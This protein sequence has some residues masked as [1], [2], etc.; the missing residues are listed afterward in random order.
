MALNG[1]IY[2]GLINFAYLIKSKHSFKTKLK[3]LF[4]WLRINFKF[5][6]FSKLFKLKKE[7]IFGYRVDAFNYSTIRFLFEEIFYRNEYLFTSKNKK[8]IIFDCGANIGFATIFFKW[9]YPESEIY[10]FEPDKKTFEI[11][12]KNVS[13]NRLRKVHL[14]N[15]AI[16]DQNGKID[17]FI[18]SKSPGS[19]V[20]STKQER[21]PKD[22]ITVDCLSLSSLIKEKNLSKID[23][24]K[25]D[26]EGSESEV[27][28]DLN[29]NHQ[30]K[31]IAKF[32][33]EYHHKISG[34]KSQLSKFLQV[35]ESNGF[36]YQI[37]ARCI[38]INAEDKFQDVLLYI[39]K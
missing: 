13:Q 3:I 11:L 38:P 6:F 36:E 19:L 7:R 26:I 29:K 5:I 23:Y 8:P 20:M 16:S 34:H 10:A 15:S 25:M 24:I 1:I 35:F 22:K 27:I 17:F 31:N 14:F 18:D 12:K 33:I 28:Q 4:T 21:M 32:S 9:L 2:A 30:L 37:D 39:Y